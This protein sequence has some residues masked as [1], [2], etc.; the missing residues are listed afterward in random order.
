MVIE[1]PLV[2]V[3]SV[4]WR[5]GVQMT[6]PAVGHVVVRLQQAA[7]LM[8]PTLIMRMPV[9]VVLMT[10]CQ[11]SWTPIAAVKLNPS[12]AILLS[13]GKVSS[14]CFQILHFKHRSCSAYQR[15]LC[16][17][18]DY[19]ALEEKWSADAGHQFDLTM[20]ENYC[21]CQVGWNNLHS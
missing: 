9:T 5:P 7:F 20:C 18:K 11:L 8:T 13:T 12:Q 4:Q 6:S 14:Q 15:H 21:V 16:R 10:K 17:V 3:S 2:T 19:S 1:M